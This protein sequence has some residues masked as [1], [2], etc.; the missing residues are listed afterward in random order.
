MRVLGSLDTGQTEWN[1]QSGEFHVLAI[2]FSLFGLVALLM[3]ATGLYA[4]GVPVRQRRRA[5][6]IRM[7]LGPGER[8]VVAT[9]LRRG[10]ALSLVEVLLGGV[11]AFG[12]GGR[13]RGE[14]GP[15]GDGRP[16]GDRWR[17]RRRN[18][19]SANAITRSVAVMT[20]YCRPSAP[21]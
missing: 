3:A 5:I 15:T 13:P 18:H 8:R 1:Q 2:L 6:G 10:S 21:M 17:D 20:M 7:V 14:T 12:G 19:R 4:V 11:V 9:I 16:R